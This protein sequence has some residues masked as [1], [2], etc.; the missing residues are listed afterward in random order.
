VNR[1]VDVVVL[2][3]VTCP[4]CH[5]TFTLALPGCNVARG[6]VG[7]DRITS[8]FCTQTVS[9]PSNVSSNYGN[10]DDIW[11]L[12]I[13]IHI[14]KFKDFNNFSNVLEKPS[15]EVAPT[16]LRLMLLTYSC[17]F[18]SG[19]RAHCRNWLSSFTFS[20]SRKRITSHH[21]PW[22]LTYNPDKWTWSR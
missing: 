9:A 18:T 17:K 8:A 4:T 14:F 1:Q 11:I 7:A 22:T 19:F 16:T 5:V 21:W 6:T 3:A 12:Y 2:A 13:Y 10:A 20:F 15:L